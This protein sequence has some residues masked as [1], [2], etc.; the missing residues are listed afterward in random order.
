ME[1]P[2][3]ELF[4]LEENKPM[5]ARGGRGRTRE[6][7]GKLT[8]LSN[9]TKVFRSRLGFTSFEDRRRV[10]SELS[11]TPRP[12]VKNSMTQGILA[13]EVCLSTHGTLTTVAD[14]WRTRT[15][16]CH[17]FHLKARYKHKGTRRRKPV[18]HRHS[19]YNRSSIFRRVCRYPSSP[20]E[21]SKAPF[22]TSPRSVP[23]PV[24]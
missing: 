16:Q 2:W 4:L 12:G 18:S 15:W 10:H 17:S 7:P 21:I 11:P 22:T 24:V 8:K 5:S 14:R 3:G 13:V 9:M 20:R 19:H 1:D 23:C 6:G